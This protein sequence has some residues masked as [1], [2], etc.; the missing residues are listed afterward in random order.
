MNELQ[1]RKRC[2]EATIVGKPSE[3]DL[4]AV[5]HEWQIGGRIGTSLPDLVTKC[6]AMF[7]HGSHATPRQINRPDG[8]TELKITGPIFEPSSPTVGSN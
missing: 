4:G 5:A 2:V 7:A 8:W 6:G 3:D 1:L